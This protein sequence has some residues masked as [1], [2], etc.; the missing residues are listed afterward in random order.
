MQEF[1]FYLYPNNIDVFTNLDTWDGM[2]YKKVYNPNLKVYGGV[3]NKIKIQ[4]RNVDQK[5][6]N[7]TGYATVFTLVSRDKQK[8]VL[9]KDCESYDITQGALYLTITREE[10]LSIEKGL[11]T[12]SL[13]REVRSAVDNDEYLVTSSFPLYVDSQYGAMGVIEIDDNIKGNL[14]ATSVTKEWTKKLVYNT[15]SG[16]DDYF[17][18]GLVDAR[19]QFNTPQTLHSFQVYM[20]NYTGEFEIQGSLSEGGNPGTWVTISNTSY[21]EKTIDLIN[22]TGKWNF[23]RFKYSP[24]TGTVDKVLYR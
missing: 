11:Y 1:S 5:P 6:V 12:Y 19:P 22:I 14:N 15:P 16:N 21:T 9:E 3:D 18:S 13:R 4:V 10:L 23:F 7:L 2:R 17:I 24:E 8:I 20:T